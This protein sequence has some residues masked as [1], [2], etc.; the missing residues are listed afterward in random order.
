MDLAFPGIPTGLALSLGLPLAWEYPLAFPVI[1]PSLE[2]V[3][4]EGI[5]G[6]ALER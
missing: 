1:P 4:L 5:L 2:L 3:K 6:Q